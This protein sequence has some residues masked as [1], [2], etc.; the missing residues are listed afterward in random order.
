MLSNCALASR[1]PIPVCLVPHDQQRSVLFPSFLLPFL[2]QFHNL[3]MPPQSCP[4]PTISTFP[5][6]RHL[7][8]LHVNPHTFRATHLASRARQ[9]TSQRNV[10]CHRFAMQLDVAYILLLLLPLMCC[11]TPTPAETKKTFSIPS[12][13]MTE[14]LGKVTL[15]FLSPAHTRGLSPRTDRPVFQAGKK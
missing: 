14:S 4:S 15:T 11:A 7:T 9:P 8:R 5:C 13:Y 6:V 3:R 10:A 12:N 2:L 1:M